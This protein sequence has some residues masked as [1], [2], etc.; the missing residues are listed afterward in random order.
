VKKKKKSGQ[1]G[2]RH[3]TRER[4]SLLSGGMKVKGARKLREFEKGKAE[5]ISRSGTKKEGIT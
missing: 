5:T 2:R 1:N 4:R 3:G